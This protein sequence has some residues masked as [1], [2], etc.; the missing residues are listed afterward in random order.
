MI[1]QYVDHVTDTYFLLKKKKKNVG[2]GGA[3]GRKEPK[4]AEHSG[5]TNGTTRTI[6]NNHP[7]ATVRLSD[8]NTIRV[9]RSISN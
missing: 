5:Q 9:V 1:A 6:D 8:D 2:M 4:G 3:G 7:S